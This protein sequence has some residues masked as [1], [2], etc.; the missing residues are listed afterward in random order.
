MYKA[1]RRVWWAGVVIWKR[2]LGSVRPERERLGGRSCPGQKG[3]LSLI[4]SFAGAEEGGLEGDAEAVA[5]SVNRMIVVSFSGS[6]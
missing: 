3:N 4:E 5:Q 1:G 6:K 2:R